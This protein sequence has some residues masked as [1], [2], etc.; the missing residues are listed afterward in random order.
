MASQEQLNE[1]ISCLQKTYTTTSNKEREIAEKKLS[2]YE[3][4]NL[5]NYIQ[6]FLTLITSSNSNLDNNIKLSIISML[7]RVIKK[8]LKIT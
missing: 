7:N 5:I 8:I 4:L 3:N 2:E 1:I 6:V